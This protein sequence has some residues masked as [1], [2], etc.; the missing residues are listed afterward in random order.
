MLSIDTS[1]MSTLHAHLP[2]PLN[3]TLLHLGVQ[4]IA[5]YSICCTCTA[6]SEAEITEPGYRT[7]SWNRRGEAGPFQ[8]FLVRRGGWPEW[9]R[10]VHCCLYMSREMS[11]QVYTVL[12]IHRNYK[13]YEGRDAKCVC[14]WELGNKRF[15]F[16]LPLPSTSN[17]PLPP[18][19]PSAPPVSLFR[20][21]FDVIALFLRPFFSFLFL[22]LI[23]K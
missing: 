5:A 2:S 22:S 8:G 20:L 6:G 9:V 3:T 21:A 14:L 1:S 4:A 12:N 23:L 15:E 18:L 10:V 11:E 19:H 16:V 7:L 13:V 17:N